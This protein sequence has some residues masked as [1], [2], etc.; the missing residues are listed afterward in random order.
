MVQLAGIMRAAPGVAFAICDFCEVAVTVPNM[1]N[2]RCFAASYGLAMAVPEEVDV[3]GR[4]GRNDMGCPVTSSGRLDPL[5]HEVELQQS[6]NVARAMVASLQSVPGAAAARERLSLGHV[7]E[8]DDLP[9]ITKALGFC[10]KVVSKDDLSNPFLQFNCGDRLALTFAISGKS[11][12][13]VC[14]WEAVVNRSPAAFFGA[15]RQC[16]AICE[17][18]S[19][20]NSPKAEHKQNAAQVWRRRI[21]KRIC[22]QQIRIAALERRV[23]ELTERLGSRACAAAKNRPVGE[24]YQEF[25][26]V[27]RQV[28]ADKL[29]GLSASASARSISVAWQALSDDDRAPHKAQFRARLQAWQSQQETGRA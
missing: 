1:K 7:V 13:D 18:H 4:A 8:E 17:E 2:G 3:Q 16:Q 15:S 10:L 19:R 21:R 29:R 25:C 5:R 26:K 14:H 20:Y 11:F 6:K 24:G 9:M 23:A 12:T 28:H 22:K 27:Y